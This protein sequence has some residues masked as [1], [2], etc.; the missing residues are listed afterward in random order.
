MLEEKKMKR[1]EKEKVQE[2]KQVEVHRKEENMK[3][4]LQTRIEKDKVIRE[5]EKKLTTEI[6]EMYQSAP[7]QDFIRNHSK[8]LAC[9]FQH[10]K[11]NPDRQSMLLN[12]FL[13]FGSQFQ[14]SSS[15]ISVEQLKAVF[16]SITREKQ[17]EIGLNHD[18]FIQSLLRISCKSHIGLNQIAQIAKERVRK[19]TP[20]EIKDIMK[21][22][23]SNK[24]NTTMHEV[25][26]EEDRN[27]S[28]HPKL[29]YMEGLLIFMDIP[30]DLVE[31]KLKLKNLRKE[32]QRMM[33]PDIEKDTK[34]KK[35]LSTDAHAVPGK[36]NKIFMFNIYL[37]PL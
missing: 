30:S 27:E 21:E 26:V 6:I 13:S 10:Y 20:E 18:D 16:R 17:G 14:I 25:S 32:N 11:E 12:E 15:L 33:I 36:S 2:M 24:G 19:V 29:D 28:L 1:E 23:K 5:K 31:L 37:N 4:T 35:S 3:K 8:S 22:A 7:F 9:I 34:A